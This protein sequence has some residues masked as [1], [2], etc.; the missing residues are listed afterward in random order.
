MLD[1]PLVL[2]KKMQP[3]ELKI[4]YIGG[5]SREWA[6]KLMFDLALAPELTG[7]VALYD[8]DV[9]SARL[10]A[11]LG[12]WLNNSNFE[13]VVS[14]WRYEVVSTLEETLRGADFVVLSIQPGTLEVM[15]EEIAIAEKYGLFF[16]VGDTT[17][18]PGL[19]RGLRSAILYAD[20]AHAIAS[21]CPH[22]WV[23]NYTNPMSICTHTLTR[24]EPG[25][26]V[27]GCCHEVFSTQQMLASLVEK[28]TGHPAPPRNQV[29]VNVTGINHFTWID[30]ARW[31]DLDLFTLVGRHVQE[32][33]VVRD[34]TPEEVESWH[35][36]FKAV[37]QIK[38]AL[39]IHYGL[40]GA[41]GNRHL[42]EFLPCFTRSPEE[43]FRWGII[44][45]PIS[46]RIERWRS[47]PQKTMDLIDGR[48]P[49]KVEPS[50]E[51]GVNMIKALLGLGDVITNVNLANAGQ[52]S[53]LPLGAVVETNARFSRNQVQPLAAGALPE[54]VQALVARHASNQQL[55]IEAAL[56]NDKKLAFQAILNDPT[57]YLPP[58]QA[59]KMF[60]EMLVASR[61]F[62][63]GWQL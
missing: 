56:A 53:N 36:W 19:V 18:A 26:K 57:T 51:E 3:I 8:I 16:P 24:V 5:G 41:A 61:E 29:E 63:P 9:D 50:G 25:L 37:H 39:F 11:R 7:T 44:R 45:T 22:A 40:L 42:A 35:D 54:G 2:V 12:E 23:I 62:L 21:I 13:E 6:R 34:Y 31:Q 59:W 52:V 49:L 30:R 27:F 55:I 1:A 58:D 28:Y 20:F 46:Y 60:I 48:T 4:A 17:G 10:N 47:A 38:F 14:H 15:G 43:L 32:P 33:G